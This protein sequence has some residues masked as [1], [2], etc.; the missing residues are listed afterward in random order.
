MS[1]D[2]LVTSFAAVLQID[3]RDLYIDITDLI[4]TGSDKYA[5]N[6]ALSIINCFDNGKIIKELRGIK[7][8]QKKKKVN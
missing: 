7:N 4:G 8:L 2:T 6:F 3:S 1:P 5:N